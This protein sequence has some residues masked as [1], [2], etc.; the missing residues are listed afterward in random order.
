MGGAGR[1]E[2]AVAFVGAW[3]PDQP[4]FHGS[5]FNRAG[6]MFQRGLARA[7]SAAGLAPSTI[8]SIEP[9]PAFPRGTRLFG[10]RGRA[11]VED[12]HVVRFLPFVNMHPLKAVTAG[13]AAV[14]ALTAWAWRHRKQ[15][16]IIHCF[17]LTMPPGIFLLFAA[18]LTGSRA[19]VSLADV[20]KP[21]AVVPDTWAWR[22]DYWVQR[23]IIPR[24]D[25]IL[26]Q[27]RAVADELAHGRQVCQI[28]GG[29]LGEWFADPPQPRANE[30]PF[31]VVL[32][33]TLEPYNG[34]DVV[35]QA[36]RELGGDIALI[37]AGKGSGV[38]RVQEAAANDP[39]ITYAGV[40]DFDALIE[41]YRSAD[42]LLNIRLTR[43]IDT[44]YFFPSKLME[45]LASGVPV[46]STSSA[47]ISAEF[48][49]LPYFLS[50]ETPQAVAEAIA[51]IARVPPDERHERGR[52]AWQFMLEHRTWEAQGPTIREY[53]EAKVPRTA[54]VP[55]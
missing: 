19:F 50:E 53:V 29:I 52:R 2:P 18:R 49:S 15:P 34:V 33:G 7:W 6:Q 37:V 23:Q 13:V 9:L 11:D 40:L 47:D 1:V 20:C 54:E 44:R 26:L 10:R 4:A 36:F 3:V 35:L 31:R 55:G 43:A 48:G 45:L 25:G 41:L 22:L 21:G 24:F 51:A 46:L 39:R 42:L 8:Y 12:G 27:S 17:N 16:R 28:K 30:K 5:A 38:A 32:A 14:G